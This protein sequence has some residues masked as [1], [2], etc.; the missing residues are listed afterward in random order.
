MRDALA[1]FVVSGINT[2]IPFYQFMLKHPDYLSGKLN[3]R[4][5]EDVLLQDYAR[6]REAGGFSYDGQG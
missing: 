1:K 6:Q 3:T 5:V 2:T 4:W